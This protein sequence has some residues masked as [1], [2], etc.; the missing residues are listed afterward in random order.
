[1]A[2]ALMVTRC[3]KLPSGDCTV[4]S[5]CAAGG[6]R[7]GDYSQLFVSTKAHVYFIDDIALPD[8]ISNIN[9]SATILSGY[10]TGSNNSNRSNITSFDDTVRRTDIT[11]NTDADLK[12]FE[13]ADTRI[14]ASSAATA[15]IGNMTDTV[16]VPVPPHPAAAVVV[17]VSVAL[18][19][20]IT[21]PFP[22]PPPPAPPPAA[23]AVPIPVS[24][25]FFRYLPSREKQDLVALG[26]AELEL[27]NSRK[28]SGTLSGSG[29]MSF[30]NIPWPSDSSVRMEIFLQSR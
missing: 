3:L 28:P 10:D 20:T 18:P 17:P 14:L 24:G 21:A 2:D 23:A 11:S 12:H 4:T 26:L 19:P 6:S 15:S 27:F 5:V 8:N 7:G 16:P 13:G 9:P 1:M 22:P 30:R 29:D 25:D